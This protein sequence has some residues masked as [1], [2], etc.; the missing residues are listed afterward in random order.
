MKEGK[1]DLGAPIKSF[2]QLVQSAESDDNQDDQLKKIPDIIQ[3]QLCLDN[4]N[5]HNSREQELHVNT[6]LETF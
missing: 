1:I 2:S 3:A 5:D 6:E 4:C